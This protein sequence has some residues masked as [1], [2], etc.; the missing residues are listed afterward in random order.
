MKHTNSCTFEISTSEEDE[1][2]D[3]EQTPVKKY[4]TDTKGESPCTERRTSCRLHKT[5]NLGEDMIREESMESQESESSVQV[6]KYTR[7]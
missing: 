1:N 3:L 4:L 2:Q 5:K 6:Y 7:L